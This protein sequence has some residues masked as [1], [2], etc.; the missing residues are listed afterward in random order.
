LDLGNKTITI[1]NGGAAWTKIPEN[2]V[3]EAF[4]LTPQQVH[5]I[6]G[7]YNLGEVPWHYGFTKMFGYKPKNNYYAIDQVVKLGK[8]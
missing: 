4:S 3:A 8:D 2:T 1:D 7:S 6:I 5:D